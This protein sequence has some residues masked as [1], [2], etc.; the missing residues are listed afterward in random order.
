MDGGLSKLA[1]FHA[2]SRDWLALNVVNGY[3]GENTASIGTVVSSLG[4][5]FMYTWSNGGGAAAISGLPDG[6]Y[7]VTVTDAFGCTASEMA[8]VANFEA[9]NLT[10]ATEQQAGTSGCLSTIFTSGG[11]PPFAFVWS[12]G[13]TGITAT[14]LPAGSF[15]VTVTDANGCTA[16]QTDSCMVVSE[17]S[18]LSKLVFFSISPN[19]ANSY[20]TIAADLTSE[21][22]VEIFDLSGRRVQRFQLSEGDS[23]E[24]DVSGLAPGVYLIALQSAGRASTQKLV[25][26]R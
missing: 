11:I 6:S 16:A 25:I 12:N 10:F 13:Q 1:S 24:L 18:E 19:P 17:A 20:V 3:C 9:M 7:S 21:A 22:Q 4:A 26:Q 14:N 15:G 8:T 23:P 5:P 2:V